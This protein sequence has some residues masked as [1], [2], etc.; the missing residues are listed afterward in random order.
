M[1][2]GVAGAVKVCVKLKIQW[3]CPRI[4]V[5]TCAHNYS[6]LYEFIRLQAGKMMESLSIIYRP[7]IFTVLK[8]QDV[9]GLTG[10]DM[11]RM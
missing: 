8:W 3:S 4:G 5:L 7:I 11:L 9:E 2:E 6:T 10:N 1:C